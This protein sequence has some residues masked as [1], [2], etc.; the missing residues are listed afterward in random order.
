ME[1]LRDLFFTTQFLIDLFTIFLYRVHVAV[2]W[3]HRQ[4]WTPFAG[5]GG[6][7]K[8]KVHLYIDIYIKKNLS[9]P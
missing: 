5:G 9:S 4:S 3:M 1:H 6:N 7:Y 8:K 2:I